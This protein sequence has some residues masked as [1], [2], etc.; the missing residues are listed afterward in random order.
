M[1]M[2]A[3]APTGERQDF[4]A[5][6]RPARDGGRSIELLVKGARCAACLSK[7]EREMKALPAVA[8]A[9]EYFDDALRAR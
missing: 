8:A 4:S 3:P 7:I 1:A 6:L 2:T 9:G 5:F